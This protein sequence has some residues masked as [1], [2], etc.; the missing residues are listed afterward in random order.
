MRVNLNVPDPE[1][2]LGRVNN[3]GSIIG[4]IMSGVNMLRGREHPKHNDDGKDGGSGDSESK[5]L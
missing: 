4:A 2:R 1:G 5:V 3:K